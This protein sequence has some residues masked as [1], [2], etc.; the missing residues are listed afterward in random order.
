MFFFAMVLVIFN[1]QIQH[2][3]WL[4]Y[5]M[6]DAADKRRVLTNYNQI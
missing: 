3:K 6:N 2:E 4:Q 5:D 1:A